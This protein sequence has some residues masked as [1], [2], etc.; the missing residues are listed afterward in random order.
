MKLFAAVGGARLILCKLAA[1]KRQVAWLPAEPREDLG[2]SGRRQLDCVQVTY[3]EGVVT[4]RYIRHIDPLAIN[5]ME[6]AVHTADGDALVAVVGTGVDLAEINS[7]IYLVRDV[8][9]YDNYNNHDDHPHRRGSLV[10]EVVLETKRR[11]VPFSY[12]FASPVENI[13]VG[14]HLHRVIVPGEKDLYISLKYTPSTN[15]KKK[16]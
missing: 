16:K 2:R 6:V 7:G 4:D 10:A 8:I 12:F 5:V 1:R 14:K 11:L 15:K 3:L 13:V 9:N